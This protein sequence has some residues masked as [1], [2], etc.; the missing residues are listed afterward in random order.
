MAD[1]GIMDIAAEV[2][3][4]AAAP[5][6]GTEP[7]TETPEQAEEAGDADQGDEEPDSEPENED[8][9][10]EHEE[11]SE[12]EPEDDFPTSPDAEEDPTEGMK[13]KTADRFRSLTDK[14]TAAESRIAEL[15]KPASAVEPEP[16]P[17]SAPELPAHLTDLPEAT[18]DY[19][20]AQRDWIVGEAKRELLAELEPRF[21]PAE[22]QQAQAQAA[23]LVNEVTVSF[24]GGN[25][26]AQ[27]H[28]GQITQ[29]IKDDPALQSLCFSGKKDLM[30]SGLA[31]AW[32]KVQN[33]SYRQRANKT[34]TIRAKAAASKPAEGIAP[35]DVE[36]VV[37]SHGG[38]ILA[39]Y[40]EE[41]AKAEAATG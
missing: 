31:L 22:E 40:A 10:G 24:F 25:K 34:K 36:P 20:K 1:R 32:E 8:E 11:G 7:D 21:K 33:A 2:E 13:P 41:E 35:S 23:N 6:P 14:L 15:T 38:D 12:E 5:A 18:Q 16:E 4:E 26:E 17:E 19:S 27:K 29:A 37:Q 3:Q 30:N 28:E 9:T 39:I